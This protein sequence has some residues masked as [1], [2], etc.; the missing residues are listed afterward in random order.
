MKRKY[1]QDG[2][3]LYYVTT[4]QIK[5]YILTYFGKDSILL[6]E[7]DNTSDLDKPIS[8]ATQA[9]LNK[10]L[11]KDEPYVQSVNGNI[12]NIVLTKASIE[13]GNVDNTSDVLKPISTATQA[14]LDRK[15]PITTFNTN[16]GVVNTALSTKINNSLLASSNGVATLD[17]NKFVPL[18]QIPVLPKEKVPN[19]IAA[20]TFSTPVVI[21]L[22]D[23]VTGSITLDGNTSELNLSSSLKNSGVIS[24][25]YGSNTTVNKLT[26]D[27]KGIITTAENLPIPNASVTAAG[28][29]KLND[30]LTSTSTTE[31]GTAN[32]V[33]A[34][35]NVANDA[36]LTSL[37]LVHRGAANGV[38][39]LD[40]SGRVPASQLPESGMIVADRL[41]TPRSIKT[42]GDAVWSVNFNGAGD[43]TSPI[44]LATVLETPGTYGNATHIPSVTIDGKGR[45]TSVTT[46]KLQTDFAAL[47][48]KPTTLTGYGIT[49]AYTKAQTDTANQATLVL[50]AP[51]G[52]V[53]Y[54]AARNAPNGWL[55]CNG[56]AVDRAVY[57]ELFKIIGTTFGAGNGTTTFNLPDLRGEFIRCWD[58]SR[59]IDGGRGLGTVQDDQFRSH[60]HSV[61]EGS[62][63]PT[64]NT[65]DETMTS[66]DDFTQLA[67]YVTTTSAAGGQETRPRNVALM[68]CIKI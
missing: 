31:A 22:T 57:A 53:M 1:L 16:V 43:V 23:D 41:S 3:G 55:P 28:L 62:K 50:A 21:N 24:G 61:K 25:T 38:A 32:S 60:T 51:S 10:R 65:G 67:S 11:S 63:N 35:Y 66:G 15:L 17:T 37:K 68:A 19:A 13:L 14:E 20:D 33:R 48:A 64:W 44:S 54:Y 18:A 30:T 49:D 34:V 29:V 45:I 39:S 26:I 27:P 40:A 5:D 2:R 58:N 7:V 12:G 4:D 9:A 59:G 52:M 42:S 6:G 46:V 47:T 8:V 36:L 56:Q